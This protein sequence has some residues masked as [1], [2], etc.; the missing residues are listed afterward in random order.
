MWELL[1]EFLQNLMWVDC[2]EKFPKLFQ[3]LFT[4]W[5]RSVLLLAGCANGAVRFSFLSFYLLPSFL[6]FWSHLFHVLYWLNVHYIIP[7]YSGLAKFVS[8]ISV[9]LPIRWILVSYVCMKIVSFQLLSLLFT[10]DYRLTLLYVELKTEGW[11]DL[12]I[13]PVCSCRYRT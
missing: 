9:I 11:L 7:Y 2:K 5:G 8:Y 3:F 10:Q 13:I 6:P 4:C 12:L 1:I